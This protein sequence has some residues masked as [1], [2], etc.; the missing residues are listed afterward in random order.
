MCVRIIH[1]QIRLWETWVNE[2]WWISLVNVSGQLLVCDEWWWEAGRLQCLVT[3]G[4]HEPPGVSTHIM[5]TSAAE[6][7]TADTHSSHQMWDWR[8]QRN[9]RPRSDL[10]EQLRA[11]GK[12]ATVGPG[13]CRQVSSCCGDIASHCRGLPVTGALWHQPAVS[14]L[15]A[16]NSTNIIDPLYYGLNIEHFACLLCLLVCSTDKD[17]AGCKNWFAEYGLSAL[18]SRGRHGVTTRREEARAESAKHRL[19]LRR[20]GKKQER[21]R[22]D[23]NNICVLVSKCGH[24]PAPAIGEDF[25]LIAV[26]WNKYQDVRWV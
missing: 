22:D 2:G 13:H 6:L 17:V 25:E 4:D 18:T 1:G 3:T 24:T 23:N 11:P 9:L 14:E 20:T 10:C 5:Q 7:A 26:K 16:K 21:E 12:E 19:V 15:R 8:L